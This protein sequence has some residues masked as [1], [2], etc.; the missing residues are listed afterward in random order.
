MEDKNSR[1]LYVHPF[2][3]NSRKLAKFADSDAFKKFISPELIPCMKVVSGLEL[4]RTLIHINV[5]LEVLEL[6]YIDYDMLLK[7]TSADARDFRLIRDHDM[8]LGVKNPGDVEFIQIQDNIY[9]FPGVPRIYSMHVVYPGTIRIVTNKPFPDGIYVSVRMYSGDVREEIFN[10]L[11]Y[12]YYD[13]Q[14]M[15]LYNSGV[16][17]PG[18]M[19][20]SKRFTPVLKNNIELLRVGNRDTLKEY[21]S[22]LNEETKQ[23]N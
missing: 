9:P 7:P 16:V 18:Y 14:N 2:I 3:A 17:T 19:D 15:L 22:D 20:K 10:K 4:D 1:I 11:H 8:F 6:P 21:V 23:K 12:K 13:H 5:C